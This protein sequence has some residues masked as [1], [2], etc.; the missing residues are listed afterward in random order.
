MVCHN[1]FLFLNKNWESYSFLV[2]TLTWS[3]HCLLFV[4]K[5]GLE[6][7]DFWFGEC[8]AHLLFSKWKGITIVTSGKGCCCTSFLYLKLFVRYF[9][10]EERTGF[11]R[12]SKC[13]YRVGVLERFLFYA[14]RLVVRLFLFDVWHSL[15]ESLKPVFSD[16]SFQLMT[17]CMSEFLELNWRIFFKIVFDWFSS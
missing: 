16:S 11:E 15:W 14:V 2:L 5:L 8:N 17:D 6:S 3:F 12:A 10:L 13:D 7:P 9:L 1:W 4:I